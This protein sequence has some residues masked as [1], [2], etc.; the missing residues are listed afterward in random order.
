MLNLLLGFV[1]GWSCCGIAWCLVYDKEINEKIAIAL[2]GPSVW[3]IV[4]ILLLLSSI[5]DFYLKHKYHYVLFYNKE[6]EQ[7]R[8]VNTKNKNECVKDKNEKRV[9]RFSL[10]TWCNG[11][12]LDESS[13]NRFDYF[14]AKYLLNISLDI[15]VLLDEK[16]M[17]EVKNELE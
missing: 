12:V 1:L 4:F 14:I 17:N 9:H 5:A 13:Y 10:S 11:Y 3:F 2:M 7:I 6:T 15:D 8:I 16:L